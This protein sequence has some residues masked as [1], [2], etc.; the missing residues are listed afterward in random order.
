MDG[1]QSSFLA[2]P[3]PNS[4]VGTDD[5]CDFLVNQAVRYRACNPTHPHSIDKDC[6]S[7]KEW[8]ESKGLGCSIMPKKPEEVLTDMDDQNDRNA[9]CESHWPC[10][11]TMRRV[12]R[13]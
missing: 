6:R 9:E 2:L 1:L 7:A 12:S 5:M 10:G 3:K 13:R 11:K 8:I 4:G